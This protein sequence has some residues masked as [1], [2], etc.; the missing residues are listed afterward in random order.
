MLSCPCC[1][2]VC[3]QSEYKSS[4]LGIASYHCPKCNTPLEPFFQPIHNLLGVCVPLTFC[5]GIQSYAFSPIVGLL[6]IFLFV[7][8]FIA[9]I[10]TEQRVAYF[11]RATPMQLSLEA[12]LFL[13][14][15]FGGIIGI[16]VSQNWWPI[17]VC[18]AIQT[19]YVSYETL[20]KC[21]K[22]N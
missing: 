12:L 4:F 9:T 13:T 2:A 6:F 14:G 18:A 15:Y 7:F 21:K 22:N 16:V 8:S 3:E 10:F 17:T 1:N 11:E 19:A 5:L 20:K